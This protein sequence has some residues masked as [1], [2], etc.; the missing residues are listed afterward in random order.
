MKA[1][2][3]QTDRQTDTLVAILR[4]PPEDEVTTELGHS[5][6]ARPMGHCRCILLN[7]YDEVV[8]DGIIRILASQKTSLVWRS[9]NAARWFPWLHNICRSQRRNYGYRPTADRKK[10]ANERVYKEVL[11]LR[12]MFT[13]NYELSHCLIRR[14][15]S[16]TY[17]RC[18]GAL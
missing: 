17:G 12:R 8:G 6:R 5:C 1:E 11:Q 18:N 10:Y 14:R 2:N 9:V 4:T 13:C 3:K 16:G 15:L 7:G